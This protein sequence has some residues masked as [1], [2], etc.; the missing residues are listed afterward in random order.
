[1]ADDWSSSVDLCVELSR[2]GSLGRDVERAIRQAICDGLLAVGARLPSTRALAHDLGIARGTVA[3]AYAQLAAE[4]YIRLRPG[5]ASEVI[6]VPSAAETPAAAEPSRAP[7]WDLRPGSPDSSSFPRQAWVRTTRSVFQRLPPDVFGYG[8]SQG[9]IELRRALTAYLGRARGVR[10]SPERLMI[11]SGF[12]QALS[13]ICEVLR[14]SGARAVAMEDPCAPRYRELVTSS[15]LRIAGVPCDDEGVQ[16][17]ALNSLDVQAVIVTPA[18]QYPLGVTLSPAR[19][20]ALTEWA[21][22]R[23]AL[24][25]EDDYDGEFRFDRR[26]VGSLQQMAADRVLYVGTASKTLAP[27]LRLGWIALPAAIRPLAVGIRDRLD[28]G[29]AGLEQ[30]VLADFISSGALDRHV[31]HMRGEYRERRDYLVRV[32]ARDVPQVAV[33]GIAAGMHALVTV[34]GEIQAQAVLTAAKRHGLLLHTLD[35]YWHEPGP[36]HPQ[37][38]VVGYGRP[39]ANAFRSCVSELAAVIAETYAGRP[40]LTCLHESAPARHDLVAHQ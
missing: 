10:T 30:L 34:P 11:C 33:T 24:I 3:G 22:Q 35:E 36:G 6:W 15:G 12:T 27:A 2:R 17:A 38:I 40:A 18:H 5:A 14:L 7:R 16:V 26:P 1:M 25:I 8:S 21:R 32:L 9:T 13:L 19:R 28:R 29:N 31:R 37:A 39:P 23:N 20:N 4:G